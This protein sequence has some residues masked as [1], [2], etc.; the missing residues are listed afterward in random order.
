MV[1][2]WFVLYHISGKHKICKNKDFLALLSAHKA[3]SGFEVRHVDA[4]HRKKNEEKK[5]G[6]I[7]VGGN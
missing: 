4:L 6:T 3:S 1:C 2:S 5:G 7:K